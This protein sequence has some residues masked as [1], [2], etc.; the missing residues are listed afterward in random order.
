M[1]RCAHAVH[2]HVLHVCMC[3]CMCASRIATM[4]GRDSDRLPHEARLDAA[5]DTI[6]PT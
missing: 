2:V 3:M 6:A 1:M 5:I 4:D